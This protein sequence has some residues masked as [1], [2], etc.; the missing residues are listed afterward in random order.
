MCGGRLFER[1]AADS[2][3]HLSSSSYFI[4]QAFDFPALV[5]LVKTRGLLSKKMGLFLTLDNVLSSVKLS[6]ASVLTIKLDLFERL[7]FLNNFFDRRGV[8]AI[9]P[10]LKT[11]F[12]FAESPSSEA[13]GP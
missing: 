13:R 3:I 8:T 11:V 7:W 5:F 4:S 1:T 12:Q 6:I 10:L 2:T 9:A